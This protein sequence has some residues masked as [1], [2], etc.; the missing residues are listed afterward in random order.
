MACQPMERTGIPGGTFGHGRRRLAAMPLS[1][2][3]KERSLVY[4]CG[5]PIVFD[6][7][8]KSLTTYNRGTL[9]IAYFAC[10]WNEQPVAL[11]AMVPLAMIVS[12]VFAQHP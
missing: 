4:S 10:L 11:P 7:A 3:K 1:C 5:P 2:A 9:Q 6:Q 12:A 8:A